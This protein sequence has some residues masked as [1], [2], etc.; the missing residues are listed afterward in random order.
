MHATC[1][2]AARG[3]CFLLIW[4]HVLGLD[5]QSIHRLTGHAGAK[6]G[7]RAEAGQEAGQPALSHG[8]DGHGHSLGAGRARTM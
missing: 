5:G 8:H 7:K 6:D 2:T 4:L 1:E 3:T